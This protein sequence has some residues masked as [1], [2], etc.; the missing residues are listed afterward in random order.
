MP[1]NITFILE[2][3]HEIILNNTKIFVFFFSN[4][5]FEVC[6]NDFEANTLVMKAIIVIFYKTKKWIVQNYIQFFVFS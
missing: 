4:L 3:K 5:K 1:K 2:Q 6:C